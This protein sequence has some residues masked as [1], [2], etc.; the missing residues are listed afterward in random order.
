MMNDPKKTRL[1]ALIKR[2]EEKEGEEKPDSNKVPKISRKVK[3]FLVS[4]KHARAYNVLREELE[5][6][7]PELA[8][9]MIDRLLI[10]Y[11]RKPVV[12]RD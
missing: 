6:D 1:S 9:E 2:K 11:G 8:E 3:G 4:L 5:A 10:H 7:G 12:P